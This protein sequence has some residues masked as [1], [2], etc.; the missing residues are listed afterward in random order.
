[1]ITRTNQAYL[2]LATG[3]HFQRDG[4]W[5][6]AKE[7]IAPIAGGAAA[8]NGQHQV[9]FANDANTAVAIDLQTPD[10]KRLQSHI[11]GLSYFDTAGG[12]NVLI[13]ELKSSQGAIL[14]PN[15]VFYEDAFTDFKADALYTYTRAG[16]EQFV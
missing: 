10:G 14:A 8:T 13:A 16:F 12:S 1:I 2:E 9:N 7:E 11:L 3:M 6:E 5:L 15:R 4:Q